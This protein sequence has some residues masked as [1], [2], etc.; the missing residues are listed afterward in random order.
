VPIHYLAGMRRG[1]VAA[2]ALGLGLAA[3]S[4]GAPEVQ[5]DLADTITVTSTAVAEGASIPARFTCEGADVAPPLAWSGVPRDAAELALVVD[6]PDAP[7]GTYV[8]WVVF[9]LDPGLHGLAEGALPTAARQAR[10]S[11][12]KAAYTG[13]CPPSG[14]AHHY[15]FSLYALGQPLDLPD[16]AGLDDAIRAIDRAATARGRLTATFAK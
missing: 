3:C 6:D 12:G 16:R 10:N 5:R 9:H 7:G 1:T 8:H 14:A 13:P 2:L 15:R 4:R 11:A